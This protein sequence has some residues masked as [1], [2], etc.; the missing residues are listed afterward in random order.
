M[1]TSGYSSISVPCYC[2]QWNVPGMQQHRDG[3]KS[4]RSNS[5]AE[6]TKVSHQHFQQMLSASPR[7]VAVSYWLLNPQQIT[8]LLHC[9]HA[10]SAP[11]TYLWQSGSK[12]FL[13]CSSHSFAHLL[14][15]STRISGPVSCCGC[16]YCLL[17][18]HRFTQ[19][20][21]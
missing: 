15:L 4:G 17:I 9:S 8:A 16:I 13:S 2:F 14:C 6:L 12:K 18:Y 3:L 21:I 19:C 10:D 20:I 5:S 11:L 1:L 7:R